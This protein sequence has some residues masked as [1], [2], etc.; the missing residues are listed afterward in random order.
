M[1]GLYLAAGLILASTTLTFSQ[2][3]V[4]DPILTTTTIIGG[5]QQNTRLDAMKNH[6]T[7]IQQYQAFAGTQ[8]VLVNQWQKKIYTGLS[9]VAGVLK[10]SKNLVEAETVVSDI[11]KYQLEIA[12]YAKDDP[13]LMV[14]A[15]KS[16]ADFESKA[17][18]MV[19][20]I[21]T[22]ALQGGGDMLMDTGQRADLIN[23]IV[24]NLKTLRS[25][26][27]MASR[28]MYW[29]KMSGVL[30]QLN[31]FSKWESE[32]KKISSSILTTYKF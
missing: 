14:F 23:H 6:Q 22:V 12:D 3:L 31:P 7:L 26:S 11:L 16:E 20:Y 17:A 32:D 18:D 10:D 29:A 8:L 4:F 30:R 15:R 13:L 27:Y 2:E 24:S 21:S 25:L 1:K 19:L 9:Q 5:N 28:Q